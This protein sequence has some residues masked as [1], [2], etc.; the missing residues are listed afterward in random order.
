MRRVSKRATIESP[1]DA[2]G[3]WLF[4]T[5]SI[6]QIGV[7]T[8]EMRVSNT[9]EDLRRVHVLRVEHLLVPA[10]ARPSWQFQ[11]ERQFEGKK[12]K[13]GGERGEKLNKFIEERK[14]NLKIRRMNGIILLQ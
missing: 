5:L 11:K 12:K 2:H 8:T 14:K 7:E 4:R 1:S 9:V 6:V 3:P 13:K 10:S